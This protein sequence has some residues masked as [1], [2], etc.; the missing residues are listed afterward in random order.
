VSGQPDNIQSLVLEQ[1]RLIRRELGDVRT[2]ALQGVEYM[3]RVE[4]RVGGVERRIEELRD[5][6]ELMLKTELMGRFAH[7]EDNMES[8][9]DAMSDRV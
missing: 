6:L 8:R 2:V 3:R 7:F 1:L 5:D 9:L 4:R